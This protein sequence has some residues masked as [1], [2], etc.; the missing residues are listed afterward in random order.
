MQSRQTA[1]SL[2]RAF[3]AENENCLS[4]AELSACAN[5]VLGGALQCVSGWLTARSVLHCVSRRQYAYALCEMALRYSASAVLMAM[6]CYEFAEEIG[7]FAYAQRVH[8]MPVVG[9][10]EALAWCAKQPL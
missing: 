8:W 1:R 10:A 9:T 3:R 5:G 4:R 6:Y 7:S 2:G